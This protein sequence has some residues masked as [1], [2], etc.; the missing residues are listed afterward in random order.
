MKKL[1]SNPIKRYYVTIPENYDSKLKVIMENKKEEFIHQLKYNE[2]VEKQLARIS[3][4]AW[5]YCI[6]NYGVNAKIYV[7]SLLDL[8]IKSYLSN[9]IFY[10]I[11]PYGYK[12]GRSPHDEEIRYIFNLV[13]KFYLTINHLD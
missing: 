9:I 5:D 7:P 12:K 11:P 1:K 3:I 13:E 6:K 4:E 10:A 8:Y 2:K